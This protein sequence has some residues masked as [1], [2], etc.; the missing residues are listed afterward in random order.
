MKYNTEMSILKHVYKE[1]SCKSFINNL[2]WLL[3]CIYL[4]LN[5]TILYFL[6]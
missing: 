4:V 3:F 2:V 1:L 6:F 5:N